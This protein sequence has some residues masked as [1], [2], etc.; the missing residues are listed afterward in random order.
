M[1][2]ISL[3]H[4]HR[5]PTSDAETHMLGPP[6]E[7]PRSTGTRGQERCHPLGFSRELQDP[8]AH[9]PGSSPTLCSARPPT[10]LPKLRTEE[11]ALS[12]ASRLLTMQQML[13][14]TGAGPC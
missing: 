9:G 1:S 3:L 5:P 8:P 14:R 4:L 13:R 10:G 12:Q 7:G 6:W 2:W 11:L